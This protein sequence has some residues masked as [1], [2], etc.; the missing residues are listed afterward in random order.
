MTS[1]T[2]PVERGLKRALIKDTD[3]FVIV[4]I[5]RRRL[6]KCHLYFLLYFIRKKCFKIKHFSLYI[7]QFGY[8]KKLVFYDRNQ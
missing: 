8:K 5:W 1:F 4:D 6:Q 3:D 7:E 2:D